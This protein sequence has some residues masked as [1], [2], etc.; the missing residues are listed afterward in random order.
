MSTTNFYIVDSVKGGC[1]KTS[2]ALFKSMELAVT[3][4]ESKKDDKTGEKKVCYLD[5]DLLGTSTAV[6]LKMDKILFLNDLFKGNRMAVRTKQVKQDFWF[7]EDQNGS[8]VFRKNNGTN[9]IGIVL[10]NPIQEEKN[11]FRVGYPTDG[12]HIDY[13]FFARRL[14][15]LIREL[16]DGGFTDFVIDMPPNSD[17]YTDSIF[18]LLLHREPEKEKREKIVNLL[19]VSSLDNSHRT[20]NLS[21]YNDLI[22]MDHSW[23]SFDCVEL[24]LNDIRNCVDKED[25]VGKNHMRISQLVS[26]YAS[27]YGQNGSKTTVKSFWV[28][29]NEDLSSDSIEENGIEK[30]HLLIEEIKQNGKNRAL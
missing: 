10:S 20:A 12:H 7:D 26:S 24:Y 4:E 3:K 15:E 14:N 13:D 28:K 21:W 19:L 30:L 18:D 23:H 9:K 6:F 29:Y 11:R 2:I 17:P 8:F 1:G 5:L 27:K 25:F 16:L 22:T